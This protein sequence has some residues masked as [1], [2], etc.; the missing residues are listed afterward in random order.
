MPE[1]RR[2]GCVWN[3][4]HVWL[5]N[6]EHENE[7]HPFH[8][9]LSRDNPRGLPR[10]MRPDDILDGTP[11]AWRAPGSIVVERSAASMADSVAS[12][13]RSAKR[14]LLVDPHI[15]PSRPRYRNSLHEFFGLV[16]I[17]MPCVTLELHAGNV[18]AYAPDWDNFRRECKRH[19][20]CLVPAHLNLIVRRW[21]NRDGGERL[22]NRY[23]LTDIGGVQFG[24]GLDEGDPGATDDVTRLDTD[25]YDRRMEDYAVAAPAFKLEGELLI[26]GCRGL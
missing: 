1:V 13:L 15:R 22:H 2:P 23:I 24:V 20:P 8:A 18:A 5:E 6:A 12:M 25:A 7:R 9:I 10:V 19:L 16:G 14:I 3:D 11:E 4:A 17:G 21:T 26:R